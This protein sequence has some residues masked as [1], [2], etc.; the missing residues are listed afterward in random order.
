MGLRLVEGIDLPRTDFVPDWNCVA[1]A[2][3]TQNQRLS[4]VEAHI[5][6][7]QEQSPPGDQAVDFADHRSGSVGA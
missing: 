6:D 3:F 1:H 5:H 7:L 4:A 2:A